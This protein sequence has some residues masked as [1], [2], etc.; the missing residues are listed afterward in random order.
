MKKTGYLFVWVL[1]SALIFYSCE[2]VTSDL[3]QNY[4][5]P[6]D[7]LGTKL[8]DSKTDSLTISVND[9]KQYI[10]TYISSQMLVGQY[11][12]YQA[13]SLLK[14]NNLP[15]GYDS[16]TIVSAKIKLKYTNYFYQDSMGTVSFD[17]FRLKSPLNFPTITYDS[18]SS[19]DIDNTIQGSFSGNPTDS[20]VITI[21][22]NNQLA[23]DWLEFAADTN[24]S[25][26]N[27]G[28]IMIPNG[29]T[30]IK[31]FFTSQSGDENLYPLLE[32]IVTKNSQT[33][34][35]TLKESDGMF[36]SDAPNS[37]IQS[38]RIFLQSGVAFRSI[39]NFDLSKLPNNVVINDAL[40]TLTL[41]TANS[42][43]TQY[44]DQRLVAAMVTDTSTKTDSLGFITLNRVG[45]V[46]SIRFIVIMQN[47]NSGVAPNYGLALRNVSETG[48][49]D[50]FSFFGPNYADTSVVPRLRI[51]YTL[52][53]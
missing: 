36:V 40:L 41:D 30:A 22:L 45:N 46:Y 20:S 48:T 34:T 9:F 33:D 10:N 51:R 17:V 50:I 21:T 3:G 14:F 39:M 52:R 49:M 8:L 29:G 28:V 38:D 15:T 2:E 12:N 13:R 44:S 31:G 18:I 24:Y 53:N 19:A 7:T 47:W 37:V 11:Q 1:L 42:Y 35:L 6:D 16:A 4:I 26:K 27:R 25:V 43:I 23:K 5:S 32:I